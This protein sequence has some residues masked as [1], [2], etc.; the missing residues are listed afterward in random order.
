MTDNEKEILQ[1][2]LLAPTSEIDSMAPL[3]IKDCAKLL[4]IPVEAYSAD[5]DYPLIL[6]KLRRQWV[7]AM[8]SEAMGYCKDNR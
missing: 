4:H 2:M 7:Q 6:A 3:T 8:I 1:Y 5:T